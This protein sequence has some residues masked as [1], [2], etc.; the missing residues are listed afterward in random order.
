[1]ECDEEINING[2]PGAFAQIVSNLVMNS[3]TH[4]FAAEEEGNIRIKVWRED[5]QIA[6][7]YSD[8]G[9]GM[10][11]N[12]LAKIFDPFFTT[13]RG[14]GGTGL[15]LYIVYNIVTQ[16]FGG[17]IECDSIPG[18]GTIFRIRLPLEKIEKED[19]V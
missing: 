11:N 3:L 10:E 2:F 18:K 6:L 15:G 19:L 4:A 7:T 8:D 5:G 16:Q 9:K 17:S 13:K 14:A 12:I 1:M